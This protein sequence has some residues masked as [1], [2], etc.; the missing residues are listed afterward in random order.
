G[1]AVARERVA[2]DQLAIR[3]GDTVSRVAFAVGVEA[4]VVGRDRGLRCDRVRDLDAVRIDRGRELLQ[5]EGLGDHRTERP[6]PAG[7][8]FDLR[9]AGLH[10]DLQREERRALARPAVR[11]IRGVEG[12]GVELGGS[13]ADQ[14]LAQRL[15][16]R[17]IRVAG[18]V[19]PRGERRGRA[20]ILLR[21]RDDSLRRTL[22]QLRDVRRARRRLIAAAERDRVQWLPGEHAHVRVRATGGIE[23]RIP[24]AKIQIESLDDRDQQL[25]VAL[26]R[27]DV[28]GGIRR[29]EQ[30][31]G[32][33]GDGAYRVARAVAEVLATVRGADVEARLAGREPD[34]R[35]ADVA[36][37][38]VL[39]QVG[40]VLQRVGD[41]VDAVLRDR[42]LLEDGYAARAGDPVAERST[43]G[44]GVDDA[45]AEVRLRDQ[46]LVALQRVHAG[47]ILL[48]VRVA[49]RCIDIPGPIA[50]RQLALQAHQCLP[51]ISLVVGDLEAR[52]VLQLVQAPRRVRTRGARG[53]GRSDDARIE[54]RE[55][56]RRQPGR[57]LRRAGRGAVVAWNAGLPDGDRGRIAEARRLHR[58]GVIAELRVRT[59][60]VRE[61][62]RTAREDRVALFRNGGVLPRDRL[63][64]IPRAAARAAAEHLDGLVAA[65]S[66]GVQRPVVAQAVVALDERG[67][68]G[69]EVDRRAAPD[70]A[71]GHLR[72][73]CVDRGLRGLIAR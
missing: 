60:V 33:V 18:H 38:D 54:Q 63:I 59:D 12:L 22:E 5:P 71:R 19:A 72:E 55:K 34:Q 20:G 3:L 35:T 11:T 43:L 51:Y 62:E 17:T 14:R 53:G 16:L 46:V 68:V 39:A 32:V 49:S 25:R 48:V 56:R 7:L 10:L 2:L 42:E 64:Q 37:D 26:L 36:L 6:G 44:R 57:V 65:G 29:C 66:Q 23:V 8:R 40:L 45:L 67:V 31:N 24:V 47:E 50:E 41:A 61:I 4:A 21:E 58:V 15:H 69:I 73:E 70:R 1:S 28:A 27:V 30:T 13:I 52:V 9:I